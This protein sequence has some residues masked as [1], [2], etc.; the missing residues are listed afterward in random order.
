MLAYIVGEGPMQVIQSNYD[1]TYDVYNFPNSFSYL[2]SHIHY[3][4]K[5]QKVV[6]RSLSDPT[7][8]SHGFYPL[9]DIADAA[10]QVNSIYDFPFTYESIRKLWLSLLSKEQLEELYDNLS[11]NKERIRLTRKR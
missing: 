4:N 3:Y 2:H 1:N 8:D 5:Y 11:N 10:I 7:N 9:D 6:Y